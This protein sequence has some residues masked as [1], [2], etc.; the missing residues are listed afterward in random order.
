MK[1]TLLLLTFIFSF[2]FSASKLQSVDEGRKT[3]FEISLSNYQTLE[4]YKRQVS[5]NVKLSLTLLEGEM[6]NW[7]RE[8]K[9]QQIVDDFK[10]SEDA[11]KLV[12]SI[13]FVFNRFAITPEG[14]LAAFY[15][16]ADST[17]HEVTREAIAKY[18]ELVFLL[19]GFVAVA[20]D[21]LDKSGEAT[22]T[23]SLTTKGKVLD[24]VQG[25]DR[26]VLYVM[27]IADSPPVITMKTGATI[28]DFN[29]VKKLV[30]NNPK[31][32]P[33]NFTIEMKNF[34]VQFSEA[35]K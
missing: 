11:Q 14:D 16:V 21:E 5:G 8:R 22:H 31:N 10:T 3:S 13:E 17:T 34:N 25:D 20:A 12:E 19:Q 6:S 15:T 29:K 30:D 2:N 1:N 32:Q 18:N 35:K 23:Q 7:M 28:E 33:K 26:R 9:L 27:N 4:Y 24:T